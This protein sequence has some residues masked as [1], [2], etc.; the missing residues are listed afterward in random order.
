MLI[1]QQIENQAVSNPIMG[2]P[3]VSTLELIQLMRIDKTIG[4]DRVASYIADAYDIINGQIPYLDSLGLGGV[5]NNCFTC[6]WESSPGSISHH[7]R[8]PNF[9]EHIVNLPTLQQRISQPL[10]Q[11]TY[12]RAVL[13][14][15]AALLCENYEDFD[16][17]GQGSVRGENLR[18]KPNSLRRIV[19]HCIADLTGQRRNRIK[20]L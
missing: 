6:P 12:K 13:N 20:L 5:I 1:N 4:T 19:N 15:A 3:S 7:H 16:T 17:I 11:R 2:L 9:T 18:Q 8:L 10:W 14:E